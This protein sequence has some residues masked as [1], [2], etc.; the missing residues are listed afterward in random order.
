MFLKRLIKAYWYIGIAIYAV[1]SFAA[2]RSTDYLYLY[3]TS[4]IPFVFFGI[5]ISWTFSRKSSFFKKEN[6]IV[7]VFLYSLFAVGLY[8]FLSYTIDGDTFV[9][10]KKDALDYVGDSLVL[11]NMG[12]IESLRELPRLGNFDDWGAYLW[13]SSVF[14]IIPSTIFLNF[15][16][17]IIGTISSVMLFYIGRTLMPRRYAYMAA[18][19][20]SIASFTVL[21][22]AQ[23][24]KETIM[25]C[26]IIAAFYSFYRFLQHKQIR[27][28]LLTLLWSAS[29]LF[30][31]IPV[32]LLL[33]LSFGLSYILIYSKG[34]LIPFIS[35]IGVL[36]LFS[37]SYLLTYSYDRYMRSGNVAAIMERKMELA[38]GGGIVNQ[39]ADPLAAFI[40]PYPSIVAKE[41][42]RT[43]LYA[44]GLL[45]RLLLSIP[46]MIG[47]IYV[48]R[49]KQKKL[50]PLLLFFFACAVGVAL[51][52]KGLELRITLPHLSMMYL[53]AFWLLAKY[54]YHR[55]RKPLSSVLIYG[56]LAGVTAI[57]FIWNARFLTL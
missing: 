11:S 6:L 34:V 4:L 28:F 42:N 15:T 12:F 25:T 30:F 7:T 56:S 21:L 49:Y 3:L 44:S 18:L 26:C 39:V 50:Y 27:F 53:A 5:I 38:K 37:S 36:V 32:S 10:S 48:L 8:H 16:Y 51:T 57:C 31:R 1:F 35:V 45:F 41:I 17:C 29:L 2:L 19:S 55:T 22:H 20:Y 47:V 23:S 13:M 52:V 46:F 24:L 43:S 54:D 14:R 9:F 33:I 40:G